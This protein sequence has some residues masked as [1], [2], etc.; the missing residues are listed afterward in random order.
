MTDH[1]HSVSSLAV[2]EESGGLSAA[3]AL[4]NNRFGPS[5]G[6]VHHNTLRSR[7][8]AELARC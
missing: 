4:P 5:A 8:S 7:A 2:P 6:T 1:H 3:K